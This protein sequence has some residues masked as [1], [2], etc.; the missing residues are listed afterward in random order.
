M[1]R[2]SARYAYA[3]LCAS[4]CALRVA[5]MM[6]KSGNGDIKMA[7]DAYA[8]CCYAHVVVTLY[9]AADAMARVAHM[10][11]AFAYNIRQRA[12]MRRCWRGGVGVATF[13]CC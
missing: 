4:Y 12:L 1:L 6:L 7:V 5:A 8:R 13:S 11:G 2:Y 10:L 3:T 9:G